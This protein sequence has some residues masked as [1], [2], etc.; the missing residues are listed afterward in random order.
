[1]IL[2]HGSHNDLMNTGAI[3]EGL[4]LTD[5]IEI[6]EQYAKNGTVY[7]V[8]VSDNAV[9]EKC[10]GYDREENY[11]PADS[12]TF[13]ASQAAR[14]VD[15]LRYTDEDDAGAEHECYRLCV[16]DVATIVPMP[17]I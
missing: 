16:T 12:E 3:H 15:V 10:A 7:S 11:A 2:Y 9:V 8:E 1:M 13:R 6:A 17:T 14:G 5:N 4:C